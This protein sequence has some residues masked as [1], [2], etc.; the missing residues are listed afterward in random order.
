MEIGKQFGIVIIAFA[1]A[2]AVLVISYGVFKKKHEGEKKY[3]WGKVIL[4]FLFVGYLGVLSYVTVLSG[5]ALYDGM[6][7]LHLFRALR[8]A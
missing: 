2:A 1:A 4:Y 3:P 5:L 8:E 7:N 6:T